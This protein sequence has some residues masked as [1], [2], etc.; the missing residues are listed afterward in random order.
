VIAWK[1]LS[2]GR[3]GPFT[4]FR[5][6]TEE[7]VSAPEGVAED[8]WIHACR[9]SDLPYWVPGAPD[10]ELWRIELDTPTITRRWQVASSR[11]RLLERVA[12]WGPA[13]EQELRR[14]CA[15]QARRL[16]AAASGVDPDA[17][18]Q[19]VVT[20]ETWNAGCGMFALDQL[21]RTIGGDA[22]GDAER[23]RQARWLAERLGL[24]S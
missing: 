15:A 10:A 14:E 8:R 24:T 3:V 23:V 16:G 2:A 17:V 12:A 18:A 11:A 20:T 9:V 22:A 5:W 21:A 6:P 19:Y 13:V 4:G 1:F 7:W